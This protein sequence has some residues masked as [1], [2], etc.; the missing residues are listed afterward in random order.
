MTKT[1]R[2]F[3]LSSLVMLGTTA[4][5]LAATTTETTISPAPDGVTTSGPVQTVPPNAYRAPNGQMTYNS[6]GYSPQVTTSPG[7]K[8]VTGD[9]RVG[10]AA[11]SAGM[12][13][14]GGSER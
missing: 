9:G 11:P 6:P 1:L 4:G 5:V 7:N 10:N 3:G 14:G 8:V 13:L 2:T 12:K